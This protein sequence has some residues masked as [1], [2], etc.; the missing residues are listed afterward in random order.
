MVAPVELSVAEIDSVVMAEPETFDWLPG[1]VTVMLPVTVQVKDA[2][3]AKVGVELSVAVTVTEQV[4]LVVG[5]PVMAPVA[6]LMARPAGR[7][8][9][10]QVKVRPDWVSV[11]DGLSV[12]IA[13]PTEADLDPGLVT[14]T[15][16]VTVQVK[17]EAE[18]DEAAGVALSVREITTEHV[19]G[20]VGVPLMTPVEALMVS[21]AGR[22]VALHA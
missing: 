2:E 10:D 19:Q 4:Q 7:P 9:A 22:P 12:E 14:V 5:V 18:V 21:P 6:E 3:P 11:A 17:A 15:V 20:V 1:L 8:V 16:L 13:V